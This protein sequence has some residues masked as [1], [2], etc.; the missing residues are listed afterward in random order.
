M[1]SPLLL[2]CGLSG[3]TPSTVKIISNEEVIAVNQDS[4]G[5][6]A[7]LILNELNITA[8]IFRQVWGGPLSGNRMVYICFNRQS[9]P[10]T[11]RLLF[12]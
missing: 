7:D 2:G 8:R 10:T 3:M 9:T 5:M 11:F 4:M 12:N 1:K 6:Q